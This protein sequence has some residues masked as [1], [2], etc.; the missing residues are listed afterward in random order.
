MYALLRAQRNQQIIPLEICTAALTCD[1]PIYACVL[2]K[3]CILNSEKWGKNV[4]NC[5]QFSL[6]INL[7]KNETELTCVTIYYTRW[8]ADKGD[9]I[10][11]TEIY[12]I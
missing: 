6:Y 8:Q 11:R 1:R 7:C 9:Q 12:I 2:L 10:R 3:K 4:E 5:T